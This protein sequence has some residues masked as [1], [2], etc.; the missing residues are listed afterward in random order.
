[1]IDEILEFAINILL[2]S[3]PNTVWKFIFSL[4][5]VVMTVI[6]ASII[7]ESTQI[8]SVLVVVGTVLIVVSLLSVYR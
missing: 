6:G 4:V 2:E 5:G 8:G 1:M 7:T 3:V